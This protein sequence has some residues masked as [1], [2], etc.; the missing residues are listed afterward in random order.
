MTKK[1]ILKKATQIDYSAT[2]RRSAM[3]HLVPFTV[4]LMTEKINHHMVSFKLTAPPIRV[5]SPA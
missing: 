5:T 2:C 4:P 3:A 1:V